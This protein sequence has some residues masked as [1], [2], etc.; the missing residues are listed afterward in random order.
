LSAVFPGRLSSGED[1]DFLLRSM[2]VLVIAASALLAVRRQPLTHMVRNG[3]VWLGIF[4]ALLLGFAYRDV[5]SDAWSRIRSTIVPGYA[6]ATAAHQTIV[7]RDADG[8]FYAIADVNGVPV[9]FL[10]D[11]GASDIVLSPADAKRLGLDLQALKFDYTYETANGIGRGAPYLVNTLTLGD[12]DL[13]D[14]KVSINQAPMRAS[15]LGMAF[16]KRLSGFRIEGDRL[17]LTWL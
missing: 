4:G 10:I 14:V 2:A 9:N 6:V 15:L 3:L 11:T 1:W 7:S 16:F 12:I 17:I 13:S 5:A 8:S